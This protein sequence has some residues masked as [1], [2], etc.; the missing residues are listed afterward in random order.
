[1]LFPACDLLEGFCEIPCH[2]SC[3]L[4]CVLAHL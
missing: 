1:M 2:F 4:I 3:D